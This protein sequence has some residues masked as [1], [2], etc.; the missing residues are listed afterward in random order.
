[1]LRS[2]L[3]HVDRRLDLGDIV[4]QISVEAVEIDGLS[5]RACHCRNGLTRRGLHVGRVVVFL[6]IL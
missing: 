6:D 4:A 3:L 2:H 1:M 5:Y